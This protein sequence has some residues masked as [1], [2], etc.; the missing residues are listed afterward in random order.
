M[1]LCSLEEENKLLLSGRGAAT[2][3]LKGLRNSTVDG[4]YQADELSLGVPRAVVQQLHCLKGGE[5]GDGA[6]VGEA[7]TL[8]LGKGAVVEY[9]SQKLSHNMHGGAV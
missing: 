5:L 2:K 8:V 3:Y 1:F 7:L 6:K 4:D 9:H